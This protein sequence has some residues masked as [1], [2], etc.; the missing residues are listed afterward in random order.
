LDLAAERELG[1]VPTVKG[2]A[3]ID[4]VCLINIEG[5]GMVGVPGEPC[6]SSSRKRT[7]SCII[8]FLSM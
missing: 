3:T 1:G 5:T 6:S 2:F 7:E 4:H 8:A